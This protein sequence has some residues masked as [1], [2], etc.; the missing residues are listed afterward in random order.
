M[1]KYKWSLFKTLEFLSSRR[2]DIELRP[3]YVT[4]LSNFEY[5]LDK[6]H[7]K[8]TT[9]WNELLD[10]PFDFSSEELLLRNTYLNAQMGPFA[11]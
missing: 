3:H 10:D 5:R 9:K 8:K 4:Q 1:N 11:D 2:P 6:Q 7:G